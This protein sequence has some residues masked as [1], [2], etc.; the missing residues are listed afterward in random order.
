MGRYGTEIAGQARQPIINLYRD[1]VS[2]YFSHRR[3]L[4]SLKMPE[5][6]AAG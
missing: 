4:E 2:D 5:R 1:E 3:Y 6:E